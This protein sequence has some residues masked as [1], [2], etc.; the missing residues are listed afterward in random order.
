MEVPTEPIVFAKATS[1]LAGPTDPLVYPKTASKLDWEV[2]LAVIIG[3]R[4]QN[5]PAAEALAHVAGYALFN[6]I[7]ERAWQI[8]RGGQW[9]KGKSHD[10]FAPL[11]PWLVTPDEIAD[12]QDLSLTLT[13]NGQTMQDGSTRTMVFG[14]AH[15]IAAMSEFMTLEPG[16]VIATGTPPG[17]GMGMAPQRWLTPGDEMVLT[18]Q[19]LGQQRTRVVTG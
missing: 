9:T 14:V 19:G 4:A 13:V 18:G 2:E 16:D 6:D 11:G 8:E 17:V 3:T 12:P 15:L 5:V 10:G 7:S 1:A